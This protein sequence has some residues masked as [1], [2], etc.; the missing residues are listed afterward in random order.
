MKNMTEFVKGTAADNEDILDFCN[1]VF[2]HDGKPTDFVKLVPKVYRKGNEVPGEHFLAKENGKIKAAVGSFKL[3][4][5]IMGESFKIAGIG[6]VSVHPYARGSGYMKRLMQMA[7]D[8]MY[9]EGVDISILG[10]QRQRY[11]YFGYEPAGIQ[12][13]FYI[14]TANIKHCKNILPGI[15]L[16]QVFE[17]D[18][19]TLEFIK[20]LHEK[21]PM[22]IKRSD[23]KFY[24]TLVSWDSEVY[25]IINGGEKSGYLICDKNHCFITEF[26]LFDCAIL[27]SVVKAFL[28]KFKCR[29][30]TVW[31]AEFERQKIEALSEFC[32]GYSVSSDYQ[33]AVFNFKKLVKAMLKLK[34]SYTELEDG[35]ATFAVKDTFDR[36][37][38]TQI[39]TVKV[40]NG[41]SDVLEGVCGVSEY[42]ELDYFKAMRMMFS[43][44]SYFESFGKNVPSCVK[45]W[46]PLPVKIFRQDGI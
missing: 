26:E 39:F 8:E 32:E 16:E 2:S 25:C 41:R 14:N 45:N 28:D 34:E 10:G 38:S 46:F 29:N 3:D 44:A 40:K 27:P 13:S 11:E 43:S 30:L 31:T 24:D 21:Q 15:E 4:M 19:E 12:I 33:Y 36:E 35:E 6:S 20:N 23:D 22:L 17:N 18:T 7:R 9:S 5:D 42:I 37:K 1:Y